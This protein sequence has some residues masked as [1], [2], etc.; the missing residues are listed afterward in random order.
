Q[1]Q[2]RL[3][4]IAPVRKHGFDHTVQGVYGAAAGAAQAMGLTNMQITNAIAIAGTANNALRVTRTGELSNWK[5]LA[6]PNTA[7]EA[8]HAAL[9][10]NY[11]I[12]G[13]REV[14]EGN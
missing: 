14:F 11:G 7:K 1:V 13:P 12:T 3:S 4:D 6:F 9:L 2:C 8:M 10:A 5:G